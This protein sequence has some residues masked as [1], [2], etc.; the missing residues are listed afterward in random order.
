M[1]KDIT[2]YLN[3]K[4]SY[5][6]LNKKERIMFI[7]SCDTSLIMAIQEILIDP[8]I[9]EYKN[10]TIIFYVDDYEDISSMI[11]AISFELGI[12]FKLH[13]GIYITKSD[14]GLIVK[15]YLDEVIN[16]LS[17]TSDDLTDLVSP[18]KTNKDNY[19]KLFE[20]LVLN[21]II[22]DSI[23]KEMILTYFKCDLNVLKTSKTLY[24]NRNSLINKLE[25]IE[26]QTGINLQKFNHAAAIY[27]MLMDK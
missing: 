25:G 17:T 9:Y 7:S 5:P 6:F 15:E 3:G 19:R 24:M 23:T 12:P 22:V 18:L 27:L 4:S 11:F 10:N 26:K 14:D 1:N 21:K 8:V 16:F 13:N 20:D 2:N